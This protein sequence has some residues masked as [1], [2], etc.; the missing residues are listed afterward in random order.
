M[1]L[2]REPPADESSPPSSG[3]TFEMHSMPSPI[4]SP[5]RAPFKLATVTEEE[6]HA[7]SKIKPVPEKP[8]IARLKLD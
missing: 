3:D 2:E 1:Q 5:E 7:S 4:K 8:V 6:S